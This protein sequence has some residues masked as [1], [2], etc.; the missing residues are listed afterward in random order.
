M[1][2]ATEPPGAMLTGRLPIPST[3]KEPSERLTLAICTGAD[4]GF[5]TERLLRAELPTSTLPKSTVPGAA[6][7]AEEAEDL[8][9]PP[10]PD[11][12]RHRPTAMIRARHEKLRKE[13]RL[14]SPQLSKTPGRCLSNLGDFLNRV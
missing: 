5:E 13:D 1:R 2:K 8:D 10:H 14:L 4:P 12:P 7:K 9:A 3:V 11:R 6:T